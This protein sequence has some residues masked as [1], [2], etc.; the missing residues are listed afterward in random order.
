MKYIL[1]TNIIIYYL[2]GMYPE[3]SKWLRG[4]DA[5]DIYVSSIT[6]AELEYGARGSN[7]YEK[8]MSV[9]RQFMSAFKIIDFDTNAAVCYGDIRNDL[10]SKGNPIGANDMLIAASALSRGF[11]VV[12][13]NAREFEHIGGLLVLDPCV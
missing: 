5:S 7:N 1:D 10:K 2:K 12:T 3:I 6:V 8:N 11:A 9:Y 13:H 4:I